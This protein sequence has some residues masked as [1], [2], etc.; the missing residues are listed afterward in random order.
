M[1]CPPIRGTF[2]TRP[3]RPKRTL[4]V[5]GKSGVSPHPGYSSPL[6]VLEKR[7]IMSGGTGA[8]SGYTSESRSAGVPDHDSDADA[9]IYLW[10][11]S[12][13]LEMAPLT[14][15]VATG[16]LYGPRCSLAPVIQG[17]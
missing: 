14:T 7:S 17:R 5:V 13:H 1:I 12:S 2:G 6:V 9:A 4:S 11:L 16:K 10:P 8:V 3:K 15:A